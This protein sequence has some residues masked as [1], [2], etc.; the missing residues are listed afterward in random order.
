MEAELRTNLLE[1]A[2][3]YAEAM[4]MEMSTVAQRA[5]G[6]WRFFRRLEEGESA[7]FTVRK[8]DAAVAWFDARW[9]TEAEWPAAV[10]RPTPERGAA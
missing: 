10:A 7:S 6:D 1:L 5:L 4:G 9:P 8:Y 3:R 2:R